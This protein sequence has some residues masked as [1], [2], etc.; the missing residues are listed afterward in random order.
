MLKNLL[1]GLTGGGS[2]AAEASPVEPAH[3]PD[4]E[5]TLAAREQPVSLPPTLG[6][7]SHQ[8]IMDRQQHVVAYE[9]A[10][11]KAQQA[12]MTGKKQREFDRLMLSTLQNMDVFRLLA[13]RRAFV[14]I[15]IASL[16]EALLD[17]LPAKSVILVL[18]PISDEPLTEDLLP[19][20][21]ALKQKG[22]RFAVEPALYDSKALAERLQPELFSRMDFM[23]LDFAAP[24][25]RV[26]APILDQLPKRYPQARWL[27]RNVGTAE[28]LDV[29]LH[30]PGSHRFALFHGSFVTSVRGL[31]T[32]KSDASQTRVMQLMRL[33]RANAETSEI[34][35]QFKLDSVLLFKLL[36]FINSPV[37][38]LSRKV[39]SIEETLMLLGRDTLFKWLSMLLFTARKEDGRSVA[40]LEKSLIRA[41]FMEKLGAYRGNKLEAEHLFLTGMFSLLDALLNIPFPD[42]LNAIELPAPVR[43][44]IVNHKG[45]FAPQLLLAMACEQGDTTR[46][47]TIAK[48]LQFDDELINRYYADAVLWAQEVL[49]QSEVHSDVEAV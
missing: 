22:L 15:S 7:V 16:D 23:V 46:V 8:P 42:T 32:G 35:A 34:E 26:L 40:L 38:G 28:E 24:S 48:M 12:A 6:F 17:D 44:A 31:A 27:A 10:V 37:N 39:Q 33:L 41:R 43:E 49:H 36:R 47:H 3:L 13:Y 29:C 11:R 1:G 4:T 14:N 2:K 21:D 20:L 9:F 25:T 18:D 45:L 19:R 30:A 5:M